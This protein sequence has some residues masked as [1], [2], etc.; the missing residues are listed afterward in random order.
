MS[1]DVKMEPFAQF[2]INFKRDSEEARR[3]RMLINQE[4]MATYHLKQEYSHKKAGQSKAV[5]RQYPV[6]RIGQSK[7][8]RCNSVFHRGNFPTC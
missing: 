7:Q 6:H 1:N 3:D 2:I 4:N 5:S 8:H